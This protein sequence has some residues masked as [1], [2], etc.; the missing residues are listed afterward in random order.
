MTSRDIPA[1]PATRLIPR[2]GKSA[3]SI[4]RNRLDRSNPE[5]VV[6]PFQACRPGSTIGLNLEQALQAWRQGASLCVERSYPGAPQAIGWTLFHRTPRKFLYEGE[7]FF[8][9]EGDARRY[10]RRVYAIQH[11][12][13]G[14][15]GLTLSHQHL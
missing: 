11:S 8:R 4:E 12:L 13:A 10:L 15:D 7:P 6:L 5:L 3:A 1:F 2:A 9:F 14:D